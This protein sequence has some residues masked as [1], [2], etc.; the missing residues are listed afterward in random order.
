LPSCAYAIPPSLSP[1]HLIY[2]I[3]GSTL[4]AARIARLS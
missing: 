2:A 1:E 4:L 3:I